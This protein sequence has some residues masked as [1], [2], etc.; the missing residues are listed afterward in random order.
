M[1]NHQLLLLEWVFLP[2][3]GKLTISSLVDQLAELIGK[4]RICLRQFLGLEPATVYLS[5]TMELLNYLFQFSDA[6]EYALAGFSGQISIHWPK[7]A[8]LQSF[9]FILLK[10][11]M[12]QSHSPIPGARTI[13]TDGSG[14]SGKSVLVWKVGTT[15]CSDVSHMQVSTQVVEPAAVVRA[16][17]R[18]P[19]EPLNIVSDSQYVVGIV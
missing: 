12:A 1:Q 7:T 4:A 17:S 5:I 8:L 15:W 14:K 10:L 3:M 9:D 13:F 11:C 6:F 2:H 16:F 19:D 18:W